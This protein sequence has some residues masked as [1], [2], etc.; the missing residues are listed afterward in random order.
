M[1]SVTHPSARSSCLPLLLLRCSNTNSCFCNYFQSKSRDCPQLPHIFFIMHPFLLCRRAKEIRLQ[2]YLF[3]LKLY[4]FEHL[5]SFFLCNNAFQNPSPL[6][7]QLP[8]SLLHPR[9]ME[10]WRGGSPDLQKS[11]NPRCSM[12][13]LKLLFYPQCVGQDKLRA[14]VT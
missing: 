8:S 11:S 12:K 9:R 10:K 6:L 1:Y 3:L 4:V 7:F 13:Y 14:S 5:R 2:I